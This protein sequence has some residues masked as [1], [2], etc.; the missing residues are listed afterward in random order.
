MNSS[1]DIRLLYC[2]CPDADTAQRIAR[3]LVEQRLAA[4][5]NIIPGLRSIYR[6]KGEVQDDAECLL[7]IKT[8]DLQ[9]PAVTDAVRS[10]HPY[11]LPEVI[12]VPVVAGLAPYLDWVRD[13][14]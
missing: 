4:C 5:V 7:L 9:V 12:A 2:T 14:S 8:R 6:W 10:L 13:N 3:A 11:E 1:T